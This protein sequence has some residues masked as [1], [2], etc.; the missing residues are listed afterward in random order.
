MPDCKVCTVPEG[1][2]MWY[3][4]ER[5][6]TVSDITTLV[7]HSLKTKNKEQRACQE[8]FNSLKIWLSASS[9]WSYAKD[10]Y[11]II[12]DTDISQ[13]CI[14]AVLS[15]VQNNQEVL[16]VYSSKSLGKAER[17]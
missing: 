1:G 9:T 2:G 13:N 16:I 3:R 12:L 14:G 5:T 11:A 4:Q 8:A 10:K 17:H 7:R 6:L 15:Q